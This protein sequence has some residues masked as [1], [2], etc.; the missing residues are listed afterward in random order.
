LD[1]HLIDIQKF[2]GEGYMSLVS[3]GTWRVAVLK[4][5]DELQPDKIKTMERHLSTDEV[6]VLVKGKAQI[7]LGGN[8]ANIGALSYYPLAIGEI[9][10]IKQNTWH[11]IILSKDAHVIIIENDDTGKGN[12]QYS[13]IP[14]SLQ[15]LVCDS[16]TEFLQ[17]KYIT[18]AA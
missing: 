9:N 11:T 10:N 6:F 8:D 5:L 15:K 18:S 13:Q 4:Y 3:Y 7:V 16:A 2:D 17:E 1:T 12:S 14:A